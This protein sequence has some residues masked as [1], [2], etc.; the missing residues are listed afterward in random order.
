MSLG[1]DPETW[2]V[3]EPAYGGSR[4]SLC[5][6]F[7]PNDTDWPRN[8]NLVGLT[9]KVRLWTFVQESPQSLEVRAAQ[10]PST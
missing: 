6:V 5:R 4:Y 1:F 10:S 8:E 3:R 9:K 2:C 7:E